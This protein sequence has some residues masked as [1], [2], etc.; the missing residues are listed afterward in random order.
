M[1]AGIGNFIDDSRSRFVLS[2][3][4][5][6]S[7]HAV[8][9]YYMNMTVIINREK[10]KLI[11]NVEIMQITPEK[12]AVVQEQ[13]KNVWDKI[14]QIMPFSKAEE[15]P[16]P[17]AADSM[18]RLLEESTMKPPKLVDKTQPLSPLEKNQLDD[19]KRQRDQ[20]LTELMDM[21]GGAQHKVAKL[22]TQEQVLTESAR[23]IVRPTVGIDK[24]ISM[25]EVGTKRAAGNIADIIGAETSHKNAGLQAP[26]S[27]L[28]EKKSELKRQ[29]AALNSAPGLQDRSGSA[30]TGGG[31]LKEIVGN[32]QERKTAQELVALEK[33]IQEKEPSKPS[34]HRGGGGGG[35]GFAGGS[36]GLGGAEAIKLNEP[37]EQPIARKPAVPDMGAMSAPKAEQTVAEIKKAPV[38][39]TGPLQHRK[40]LKAY[41]PKYPDWAKSKS[42]EADVSLRFF[43]NPEGFVMP[44]ISVVITSGYRELDQLCIEHLKKWVFAP[45]DATESQTDQWGIITIRFRLD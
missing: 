18:K 24:S 30:R 26:V 41:V 23:P 7:F 20:K 12:A 8:M 31:E 11:T 22:M 28:V 19:L 14:K 42:I 39:I 43:V 44:D 25:E 38:E 17:T 5:I 32:V 16:R 27:Q 2:L 21:T 29:L 37:K 33:L 13:P 3:A 6:A 34:P 15:G 35:F 4:V 45:L 10:A 36:S 40:V 9:F 1:L